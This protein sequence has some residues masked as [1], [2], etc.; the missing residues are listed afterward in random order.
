MVGGKPRRPDGIVKAGA[1]HRGG[2]EA[3]AISHALTVPIPM[4]ARAR[5]ASSLSK[6][7]SPRPGG[8][9]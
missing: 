2:R 9:P 6:T 5:S 8:H 7:G 3:G 4:R 1:L